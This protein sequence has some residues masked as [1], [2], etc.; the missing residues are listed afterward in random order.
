MISSISSS[1]AGVLHSVRLALTDLLALVLVA[2]AAGLWGGGPH[3][4]RGGVSGFLSSSRL[5]PGQQ[6]TEA[7][8]LRV[9]QPALRG[10]LRPKQQGGAQ[11]GGAA[12]SGPELPPLCGGASNVRRV[13]DSLAAKHG[14]RA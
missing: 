13:A 3:A 1:S 4:L 11:R 8:A 7:A 14:W 2:V 10:G 12:K 6:P 9:V 5:L